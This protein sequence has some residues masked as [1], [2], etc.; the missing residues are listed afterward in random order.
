MSI[1]TLPETDR[2]C[3]AWCRKRR[4]HGFDSLIPVPPGAARFHELVVGKVPG[5][6]SVEITAEEIVERAPG[7]VDAMGDV[8]VEPVGPSSISPAVINCWITEGTELT[9]RDA[10]SLAM[11]LV[12]AAERLEQL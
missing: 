1:V 6:V 9:A 10:R 5:V 7:L 3:P 4:G 8:S 2:P 11:L 12:T